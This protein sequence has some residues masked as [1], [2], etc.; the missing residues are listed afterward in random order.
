[1]N[2]GDAQFSLARARALARS[3]ALAYAAALEAAHIAVV[4]D[5]LLDTRVMVARF[6][7]RRE[8]AFRGTRDLRNWLLDLNIYQ[9]SLGQGVRVHAGFLRGVDGLLPG[10]VAQLLPP[11]A[12]KSDL[13]P[14]H[15]TGHSLGG[16]L[17]TLAA[18]ALAREGFPV[19]AVYTFASPR[20][21]NGVWRREY[22]QALGSRT[23]RM[24]CTGDL[25]PYVPGVLDGYRHVGR[26]VLLAD[27]IHLDPSRRWELLHDLWRCARA[28]Q[29]GE[30]HAITRFHSLEHDYFP[31][32]GISYPVTN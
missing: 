15:F 11:G 22:A 30:M 23:F 9:R 21:G 19:A 1:M 24:R 32:L 20:V 10:L 29:C 3:A 12:N 26:E 7:D 2:T 5:P 6:P 17:A 31:Q 25:V 18:W 4:D 16:A 13:P 14:L 28:W 27:G 8:I